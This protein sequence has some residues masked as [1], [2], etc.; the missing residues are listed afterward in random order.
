MV[1]SQTAKSST[2][3][4]RGDPRLRFHGRQV[5]RVGPALSTADEAG[6]RALHMTLWFGLM[7]TD[8]DA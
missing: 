3:P 2:R 1:V 7:G 5:C 4:G 6:L 8:A